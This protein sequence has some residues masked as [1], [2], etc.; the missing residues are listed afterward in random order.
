VEATPQVWQGGAEVFAPVFD[1]LREMEEQYTMEE[2]D[3]IRRFLRRGNGLSRSQIE[4]I[5][6]LAER[7]RAGKAA[8]QPA[9]RA[10]K[11]RG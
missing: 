10:R 5:G 3:A 11:G 1:F 4:H 2:L 8:S 7:A 6:R 9:K